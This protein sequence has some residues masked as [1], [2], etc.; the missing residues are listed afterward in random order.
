MRSRQAWVATAPPANVIVAARACTLVMV[1][2]SDPVVLAAVEV[3]VAADTASFFN[4]ALV[5]V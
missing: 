5:A 4:V 3:C 2:E 1:W